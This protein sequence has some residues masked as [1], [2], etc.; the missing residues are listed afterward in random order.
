M[1]ELILEHTTLEERKQYKRAHK[2]ALENESELQGLIDSGQAWR[3]EGSV[4]RA[5]SEALK[6]GAC[7]LPE[8]DH[9]DYWGNTVP[10]WWMLQNGTKGTPQNTL[11]FYGAL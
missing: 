9:K 10:A 7:V 5:A 2:L 6:D 11:E 3:L 4:G 8:Q 1:N